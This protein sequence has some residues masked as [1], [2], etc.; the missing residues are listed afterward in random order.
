MPTPAGQ[1]GNYTLNAAAPTQLAVANGSRRYG[2]IVNEDYV[3]AIRYAFGTNNSAST[4]VGHYL[5]PRRYFEFPTGSPIPQGDVS[6]IAL[7]GTPAIS[8]LEE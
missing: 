2:L 3:N 4:T 5:G 1:T 7:A 8:W 6:A